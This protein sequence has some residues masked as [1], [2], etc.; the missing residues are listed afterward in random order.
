MLSGKNIVLI[1]MPASGKSTL[2]VLIAKCFGMAFVDSDLLIQQYANDILSNIIKRDGLPFFLQQEENV[3]L[4]LDC[5]S[6]VIAT[7]GSAVYSR[8]AMEHI[9]KDGEVIY[10]ELS[11]EAVA[12]RISDLKGRGVVIRE[13]QSF[14]ELYAERVPLYEEYADYTVA[15]DG[16]LIEDIVD[17]ICGLE[18]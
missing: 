1:G 3:L 12:E 14:D 16:K 5:K 7:G 10:L 13:G 9:K 11:K 17:E 18:L 6:T 2:G 4:A 8:R 15:C